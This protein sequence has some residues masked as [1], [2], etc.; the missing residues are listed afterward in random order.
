[1]RKSTQKHTITA[2]LI[3]ANGDLHIGHVAGCYLPAD[4]YVRY[5]RARGA[6]ALFISGTDEH[7]AAITLQAQ[8]EGITPQALVDKYYQRI[9]KSFEGLRIDFDIFYR[10][11]DPLHHKRAQ[12]FFT[13]LHEQGC[14]V[15]K[16][17]SQ[18][19]DPEA[20]V[21]LA[22]RYI[23]G[24]CPFCGNENA[25][26]DQCEHCGRVLAPDELLQPR[27]RQGGKVVKRST[28]HWHLP[29]DRWQGIVEQYLSQKKWRKHVLG[30]CRSWLKEGL[31][32]RPMTRDLSWGVPVPLPEA[33]GKVLYVW[34]DAPIG[35]I[36]A[37]EARCGAGWQQYWQEPAR[38]VH[39]VGKDNIVF[40]CIIFPIMLH[41]HGQYALPAHVPAN[42]FLTLEGGKISTS[43][44][45]AVWV[46]DYVRDFPDHIDS[47]RYALCSNMP[48]NK[49]ADF[50]WKALQAANNDELV[51]ILGNF[52]HR[53]CVLVHRYF[54]GAVPSF[55][56]ENPHH[57][58]LQRLVGQVKEIAENLEGFR[59]KRAVSNMMDIARVGNK[60]LADTEPWKAI[61]VDKNQAACI[62]Y[63]ALQ[64]AATLR[65]VSAPFLP[66]TAQKMAALLSVPQED[67]AFAERL[68]KLKTGHCIAEA[69]PLLKKIE[70][71]T[72]AA[73]AVEGKNDGD[74]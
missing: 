52:V 61:E 69:V 74:G 59:F 72:I 5:L 64:V 32:P 9:K 71:E 44:R 49:D 28:T 39:F 6:D 7:G 22:D 68:E 3:Y 36:S 56:G 67:W 17:A 15:K 2:A 23:R 40:H 27:S 11:S 48:E 19:Y 63:T 31:Q 12:A 13:R 70:D 50:S 42:E 62:L 33:A 18:Y 8:Q 20:A 58:L 66:D 10:T 73:C 34:F 54:G 65:V 16:E 35:Y 25:Y 26:G 46:D 37:T 14:F 45:W 41:L 55:A 47:L 51:G 30:Q 43:R 21:F 1:M 24:R 38:I 60:F 29:L 4:I 53:T 57:S